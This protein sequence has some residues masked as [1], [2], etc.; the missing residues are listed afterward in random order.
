MRFFEDDFLPNL[1]KEDETNSVRL[2]F[3]H[4]FSPGSDLIGNFQYSDADSRF[5]DSADPF[6][7]LF[8]IK[9]DDEAYGGELQYLFRSQYINIVSGAGYFEIDSKDKITREFAP[10]F[11]P[12]VKTTVDGDTTT[13]MLTCIPISNSRQ[14]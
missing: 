12:I 13:V 4:A 5:E 9:G 1:R 6:L 11:P 10:P 14:I 7:T 2:G 3:R 8:E